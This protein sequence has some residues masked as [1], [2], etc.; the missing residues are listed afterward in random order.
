MLTDVEMSA[1]ALYDGGWRAADKEELKAEYNLAEA[2]ADQICNA[3][4]D[5][6]K[7]SR[8][9][10]AD[11]IKKQIAKYGQAEIMTEDCG[12]CI[13]TPPGARLHPDAEP[14]MP[15]QYNAVAE[16]WHIGAEG[17]QSWQHE[18]PTLEALM[19]AHGH[20]FIA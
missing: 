6:E 14:C 11:G 7:E 9:H 18:Y 10:L 19:D 13:I 1:A 12:M 8:E 16:G 20:D 3:L 5:M 4:E 2:E 17:D 15:E